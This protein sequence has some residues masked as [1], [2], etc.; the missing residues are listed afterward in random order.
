MSEDSKLASIKRVMDNP[1]LAFLKQMHDP[2]IYEKVYGRTSNLFK[3][4]INMRPSHDK[5][6]PLTVFMEEENQLSIERHYFLPKSINTIRLYFLVYVL[7]R[8]R[9]I[10]F[11][12][13]LFVGDWDNLSYLQKRWYENKSSLYKSF[14]QTFSMMMGKEFMPNFQILLKRANFHINDENEEVFRSPYEMSRHELISEFQFFLGRA[15]VDPKNQT[16]QIEGQ[17]NQMKIDTNR[18]ADLWLDSIELMEEDKRLFN[19]GVNETIRDL[20]GTQY[21][22]KERENLMEWIGKKHLVV[23]L[24]SK[25]IIGISMRL[26]KCTKILFEIKPSKMVTLNDC[27]S[28]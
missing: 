23:S 24:N 9:F 5:T 27:L 28:K 11:I 4:V 17:S 15:L 2:S 12:Y 3:E 10:S 6:T 19:L 13:S 18:D 14:R 16:S 1:G 22:G 26:K 20:E 25:W 8:D 7:L 21:F